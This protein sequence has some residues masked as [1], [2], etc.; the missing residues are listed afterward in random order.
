MQPAYIGAAAV[1]Y[2]YL[3]RFCPGCGRWDPREKRPRP[4]RSRPLDGP[5][6]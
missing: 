3:I 6:A 1:G 5:S 2:L 4:Q